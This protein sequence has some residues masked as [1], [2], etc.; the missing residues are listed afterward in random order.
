[1]RTLVILSAV[2]AAVLL[3]TP[4]RADGP[5]P[6]VVVTV[7]DYIL[8]DGRIVRVQEWTDLLP[9]GVM[10]ARA[11]PCE[12]QA[13]LPVRVAEPAPVPVV[14]PPLPV[15]TAPPVYVSPPAYVGPPVYSAPVYYSRPAGA[16]YGSRYYAPMPASR[17][18]AGIRGPFGG[19]MGVENCVGG[20]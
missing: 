20:T 8:P 9:R 19:F 15:M 5:P 14:V 1:M 3:G 10:V 16:Y 13:N 17:F 6:G 12:V 11:A 2:V 18:G 4:A 7:A